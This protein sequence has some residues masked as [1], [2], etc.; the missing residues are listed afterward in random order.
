[1]QQSAHAQRHGSKG[2]AHRVALCLVH[3]VPRG[4]FRQAN[5]S[6]PT[7]LVVP[8]MHVIGSSLLSTASWHEWVHAWASSSDSSDRVPGAHG[9]GAAGWA[10]HAITQNVALRGGTH[11]RPIPT[12]AEQG[13]LRL[14]AELVRSRCRVHGL[15]QQLSSR[16]LLLCDHQLQRPLLGLQTRGSGDCATLWGGAASAPIRNYG[17]GW[18]VVGLTAGPALLF[19]PVARHPLRGGMLCLPRVAASNLASVARATRISASAHQR[20]SASAHQRV[21]ESAPQQLSASAPLPLSPSAHPLHP[22]PQRHST[23]RLAPLPHRPTH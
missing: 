8:I 6:A 17:P 7:P 1:M 20:I 11:S 13:R 2:K 12:H 5:M 4:A 3:H 21:G 18:L 16:R 9:T 14:P 15:P 10:R 19:A 22:M 23:T